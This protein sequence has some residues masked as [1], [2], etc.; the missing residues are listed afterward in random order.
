MAIKNTTWHKVE[1]GQIVTFMYQ[2][3]GESTPVKR[4]VLVINPELRYKKK[5][6]RTTKFFIGFQLN[7]V[8][9]KE[10]MPNR[11]NRM[12]L[13]MGGLESEDGVLGASMQEDISRA[14][15]QQLIRVL[16]TETSRYRT[17]NLRKCKRKRVFLETD[18]KQIPKQQVKLLEN[19]VEIDED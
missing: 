7:R 2:S 19:M 12:L 15:T 10:I 13:K 1:T 3:K 5:N 6:G 14:Q 16:R 18:Y 11:L 4:T 8:G 9:E 17:F